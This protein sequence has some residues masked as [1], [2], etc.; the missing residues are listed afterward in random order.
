M[1]GCCCICAISASLIVPPHHGV[2]D[3]A[4][5]F[6]TRARH[7]VIDFT[8]LEQSGVPLVTDSSHFD[9]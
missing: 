3:K 8:V 7:F 4:D 9:F 2:T 5:V 1:S 6:T